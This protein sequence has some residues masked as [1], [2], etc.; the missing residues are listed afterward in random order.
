[1]ARLAIL[2]TQIPE[3]FIS[4]LSQIVKDSWLVYVCVHVYTHM[5][6]SQLGYKL[7]VDKVLVVFS[8]FSYTLQITMH[9]G[10]DFPTIKVQMNNH[11]SL[12]F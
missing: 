7:S 2:V 5:T 12:S 4:H 9:N 8:F 6:S 3:L 11:P 10:L 1:M